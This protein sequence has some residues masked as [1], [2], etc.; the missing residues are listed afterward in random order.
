MNVDEQSVHRNL[1]PDKRALANDLSAA[2]DVLPLAGKQAEVFVQIVRQ[3]R[4]VHAQRAKGIGHFQHRRLADLAVAVADERDLL[5]ALDGAS[6]RQRAHR[7]AQRTGDD[8]A[9]VAQPDE[10]LLRHAEHFRNE[11]VQ[12]RINAR[13]CHHRQR[14]GEFGRVQRGLRSGRDSAMVCFNDGFEQVHS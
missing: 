2:N 13:E 10:L 11:P 8:I 6:Q 1:R 12:A 5:A 4:A 7:A 14:V 3:L 9:R